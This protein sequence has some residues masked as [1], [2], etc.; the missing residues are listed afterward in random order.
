M[1]IKKESTP[2]HRGVFRLFELLLI[3]LNLMLYLSCNVGELGH[4]DPGQEAYGQQHHLSC[5]YQLRHF[6]TRFRGLFFC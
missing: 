6:S 1:Y 2:R 3:I 5:K 4:E